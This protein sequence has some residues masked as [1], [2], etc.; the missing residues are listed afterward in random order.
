M[1]VETLTYETPQFLQK[2]I[3]NDLGSLRL[4][5]EAFGVNV[6]SREGWVRLEGDADK[7]DAARE[8]FTQLEKVRRNGGDVSF[9]MVRLVI[10]SVQRETGDSPAEAIMHLKLLGSGKRPPVLAKTRGQIAYVQAMRESEVVFG[11]GP[12]GTGKTYLAMAQGLHYLKEKV[13]QRLVLTRPAVEAGEALGFLPGDLKEKIFPYLRPLYDAL[14]DMLEPEEAERLIE[15][16][17][18]EIAPLAYMRGRTLKNAFIILDEAQNTTTE[19]MLMFLTRL[20]DG[21]RCVVT[22]DPSQIDLRRHV[23]SGLKEAVELLQDVEG[24]RFVAFAPKDIVR[25]PVVQR[26]IEAYQSGRSRKSE[27]QWL[28]KDEGAGKDSCSNPDV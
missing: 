23:K 5:G 20:G 11:V 6:T 9:A 25:L 28:K 17:S 21:A 8:V 18:I 1:P 15:R 2:L 14:Y 13:V 22:G 7:I 3:G 10:D 12:A 26:I 24:V 27:T 4:I 16:G 19:Q